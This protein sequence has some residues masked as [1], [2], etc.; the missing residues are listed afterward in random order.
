MQLQ[1][2]TTKLNDSTFVIEEHD[3]FNEHPLIYVKICHDSPAI[4]LTDTGCGTGEHHQAAS[5]PP[6]YFP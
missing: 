6:S 1:F 5:M 3:S 2:T 4:V